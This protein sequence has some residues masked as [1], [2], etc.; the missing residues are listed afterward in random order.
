MATA[1]RDTVVYNGAF[2]R[3]LAPG[4]AL[5]PLFIVCIIIAVLPLVY[6]II[7]NKREQRRAISS[8]QLDAKSASLNEKTLVVHILNLVHK[9]W[10]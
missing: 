3:Q 8:A 5:V 6:V 2:T 4:P 9:A 1:G 7:V 10:T